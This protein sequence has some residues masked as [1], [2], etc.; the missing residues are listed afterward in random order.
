MARTLRIPRAVLEALQSFHDTQSDPTATPESREFLQRVHDTSAT[1]LALPTVAIPMDLSGELQEVRDELTGTHEELVDVREDHERLRTELARAQATIDRL[2]AA[3][4]QQPAAQ[5][6]RPERKEKLPD[7]PKFAGKREELQPWIDQL[8]LKIG[9]DTQYPTDQDRLRYAFSR[10]EGPAFDQARQYR[11]GTRINLANVEALV[12][13]LERAFDDPDREGTARRALLTLRQ[14]NEEFSVYHAKFSAHV[15][16]A[17]LNDQAL[18]AAMKEGVSPRIRDRMIGIRPR[19]ATLNDYVELARDIDSD[20]RAERERKSHSAPATTTT[21]SRAPRTAP[22]TTTTTTTTATG[23]EPGPMDLSR[24]RGAGGYPKL[25]QQE[26]ER[27]LR[28]GLCFRCGGHGHLSTACPSKANRTITTVAAIV[29]H[30][31]QEESSSAAA[32][33]EQSEN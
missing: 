17:G 29:T 22:R 5:N 16:Y 1:I 30:D 3:P 15:P 6:D 31:P 7:I 26:R 27:R 19:P 33:T 32:S 13:I 12:T 28:Q 25:S 2:L 14:D 20:L 18:L 9:D 23:T 11:T 24:T 8:W 10:L 4:I 21:T